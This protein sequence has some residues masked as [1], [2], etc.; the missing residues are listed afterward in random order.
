VADEDEPCSVDVV[1]LSQPGQTALEI[2]GEP[3]HRDELVVV[4]A[5]VAASV[6]QQHVHSGREQRACEWGHVGGAAAPAVHDE[7]GGAH[8][9][10]SR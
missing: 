1:A 4:A 8:P 3:R 5:S 7:G 9:V 2:L 10:S 6:Q